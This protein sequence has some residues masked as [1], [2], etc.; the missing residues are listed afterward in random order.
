MCVAKGSGLGLLS[1]ALRCAPHQ[2]ST[3]GHG[4]AAL[5][6]PRAAA[7]WS[8]GGEGRARAGSPHPPTQL[9][10]QPPGPEPKPSCPESRSGLPCAELPISPQVP[11]ASFP[12]QGWFYLFTKQTSLPSRRDLMPHLNLIVGEEFG[13]SSLC[14]PSQDPPPPSSLP[15]PY[16]CWRRGR[17]LVAPPELTSQLIHEETSMPP[18]NMRACLTTLPQAVYVL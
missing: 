11:L 6:W 12:E 3:R 17:G 18:L 7:W 1:R 2:L 13:P 10:L 4:G 14:H 16:L 9:L 5:A 15:A 8:H